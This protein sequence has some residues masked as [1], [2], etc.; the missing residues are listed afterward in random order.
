MT[1]L[2][3]DSDFTL[4]N[5]IRNGDNDAFATLYHRYGKYLYVLLSGKKSM[6]RNNIYRHRFIVGT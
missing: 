6:D 2:G 4:L 3:K 5:K 1:L